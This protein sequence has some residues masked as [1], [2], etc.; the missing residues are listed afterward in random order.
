MYISHF[1]QVV[2]FAIQRG[3]LPIRTLEYFDLQ[4]KKLPSLQSETELLECGQKLIE[5]EKSRRMEGLNAVTNPTIAVVKVHFEKFVEA[6]TFQENL[7]KR[8]HRAHSSLSDKRTIADT[9]I[10][11]LWNEIENTFKDLPEDMKRDKAAE[12]GVVYVFRKNE[13]IRESIFEEVKQEIV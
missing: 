3:E 11:H 9:I 1:I 10:Q 8:H 6:Y 7:K 12:Y 2:N 4:N 5:G 13:I